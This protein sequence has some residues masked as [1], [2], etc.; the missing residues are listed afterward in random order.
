MS[1]PS[2]LGYFDASVHFGSD[3]ETPTSGAVGFVVE[4]GLRTCLEGSRPVEAVVSTS[5][6]EFRA[7][8]EMVRAVDRAFDR[9]SSLHVHGDADAVIRAVDPDISAV[10][11][12]SVA[13]RRVVEIRDRVADIPVVTYRAVDRD[14][15]DR[16]HRLAREGHR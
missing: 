7:C 16:A 5:A 1:P 15:N 2:L 13:R 3:G 8:L 10:P 14:D 9:P 6:L 12:E 4:D 11:S